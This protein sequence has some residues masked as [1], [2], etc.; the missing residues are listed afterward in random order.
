LIEFKNAHRIL[1]VIPARSGSKG[2]HDKN[3][4]P[5]CGK[6]LLAHT[7][8]AAKKS[9]VI[10]KTVVSTD[11][12]VYRNIGLEYGAEVP[13]LRPTE[14]SKDSSSSGSV[15]KHAIDHYKSINEEFDLV[16]MLQPTSPLRNSNH[17]C[18]ALNQ[19]FEMIQTREETLVSVTKA[20]LKSKWLLEKKGQFINFCFDIDSQNPQRQK[21]E[22]LY[23][24]NGAIYIASVKHFIGT[25]YTSKTLFYEMDDAVSIDIDSLED[26]KKA[27]EMF[28]ELI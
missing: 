9:G 23:L 11:S 19:Y 2:L 13:F 1:A 16:M 4:L 17:I 5:F 10:S 20:P 15:I 12:D 7:I 28:R 8:E 27:E 26:F 21:L 22:E 18:E 24:P 3:I 25:F 6:P 14:I